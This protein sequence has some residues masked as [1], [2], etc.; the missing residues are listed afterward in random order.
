MK[1]AYIPF[2]VAVKWHILIA[3]EENLTK[4]YIQN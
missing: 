4:D 3:E 2:T 1:I